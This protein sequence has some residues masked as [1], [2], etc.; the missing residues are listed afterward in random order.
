MNIS[1]VIVIPAPEKS[2]VVT[3]AL[4]NIEGVEVAVV[5]DGKIIVTIETP[6]NGETVRIFEFI[7]QMEDVLSTSMVYH[8]F[9]PDPEVEISVA[10]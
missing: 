9:E 1:S 7:T 5:A 10:A 4:N 8:Q 3:D 2:Q 6:D